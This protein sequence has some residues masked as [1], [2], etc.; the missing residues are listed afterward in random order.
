[1]MEGFYFL[2]AAI[3]VMFSVTIITNVHFITTSTKINKI[4][5][6]LDCCN[7]QFHKDGKNYEWRDM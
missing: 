5:K 3:S 1:M 7:I 4:S 2:C 6:F